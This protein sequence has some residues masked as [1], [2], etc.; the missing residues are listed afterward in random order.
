VTR[1]L[2][3]IRASAAVVEALCVQIFRGFVLQGVGR[4]GRTYTAGQYQ[5][6]DGS[7]TCVLL[8]WPHGVEEA[9]GDAFDIVTA[10]V[11]QLPRGLAE[12]VL[13]VPLDNSVA[14]VS[15]AS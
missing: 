3:T 1:A 6:A 8:A 2:G 14:S 15:E 11:A 7:K 9:S 4:D 13:D 12:H 10:F 5:Y